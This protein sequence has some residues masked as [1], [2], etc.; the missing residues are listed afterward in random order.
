[1][2]F[3]KGDNLDIRGGV[4]YLLV[5]CAWVSLLGF[6][7]GIRT[8]VTEDNFVRLQQYSFTIGTSVA[9]GLQRAGSHGMNVLLMM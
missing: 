9:G 6:L 5:H 3:P 4:A 2:K 1:M 8:A 7:E